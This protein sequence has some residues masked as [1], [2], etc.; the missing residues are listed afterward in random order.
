MTIPA[1]IT[2]IQQRAFESNQLASIDLGSVNSIG[3]GAFSGNRLASVS[4]PSSLQIIGSNAFYDNSLVHVAL[5]GSVQSIGDGAF[6]MNQIE[7]VNIAGDINAGASLRLASAF[8]GNKLTQDQFNALDVSTVRYVAVYTEDTT[9]PYGYVDE[10]YPY[11]INGDGSP[12]LIA[13]GVVINPSQL[14]I[15]YVDSQ[16][17]PLHAVELRT[18]PSLT[19]YL[20]TSNTDGIQSGEYYKNNQQL[21]LS[22][23]RS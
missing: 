23:G 22:P 5:P 1:N 17:N 13:G 19:D 7:T 12:D 10:S 14:N 11:D 21:L 9:N 6:V 15:E 4:F 20:M 18:G 8:Y 16:G 2:D 3:S